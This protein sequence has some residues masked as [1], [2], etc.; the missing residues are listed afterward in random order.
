MSYLRAGIYTAVISLGT[1]AGGAIAADL[2]PPKVLATTGESVTVRQV[3][4]YEARCFKETT[5]R[6]RG[7]WTNPKKSISAYLTKVEVRNGV[8]YLTMLFQVG[9]DSLK[10]LLEMNDKGGIRNVPPLI[11]TTIPDF[12][13]EHGDTLTK[14]VTNMSSFSGDFLGRTFEVGKDYGPIMNLCNIVGAQSSEAPE[15]TTVV[16]GT[17]THSGR[18][19]F[20]I[21]QTFEQVCLENG[22]RFSVKGSAWS[23]YDFLSGL[24]MSNFGRFELFSRGTRF[25][26]SEE[27]VECVVSEK[28]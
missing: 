11:E 16:E 17:L 15:G 6:E 7:D 4:G 5:A 26:Q 25:N 20:L 28:N 27:S 10:L 13:K 18:S 19:A 14:L 9:T 8:E 12:E 22:V 23:V 1:L 21:T 2:N 24:A 3:P